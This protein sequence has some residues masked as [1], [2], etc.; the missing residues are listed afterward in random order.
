[1]TKPSSFSLLSC[2]LVLKVF[3]YL[4]IASDNLF[5]NFIRDTTKFCFCQVTCLSTLHIVDREIVFLSIIDNYLPYQME[6][7]ICNTSIL[8]YPLY[9]AVTSFGCNI[10]HHI[11]Q[12]SLFIS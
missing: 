4:H 10:L 5:S 11:K 12:L 1:M 9:S 7:A 3:H 6:S 2:A 8:L